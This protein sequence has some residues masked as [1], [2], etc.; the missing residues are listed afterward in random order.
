MYNNNFLLLLAFCLLHLGNGQVRGGKKK[1]DDLLIFVDSVKGDV[2]S[3]SVSDPNRKKPLM[4]D[5]VIT[6]KDFNFNAGFIVVAVNTTDDKFSPLIEV[7]YMSEFIES[8]IDAT[9]F[10]FDCTSTVSMM[11]QKIGPLAGD[12]NFVIV[13][14]SKPFEAKAWEKCTQKQKVTIMEY[15]WR[16]GSAEIGML[17]RDLRSNRIDEE[18][19]KS[20][21]ASKSLTL[22]G[23]FCN[24]VHQNS[25]YESYCSASAAFCPTLSIDRPFAPMSTTICNPDSLIVSWFLGVLITLALWGVSIFFIIYKQGGTIYAYPMDAARALMLESFRRLQQQGDVVLYNNELLADEAP[26]KA[27]FVHGYVDPL[28]KVLEEFRFKDVLAEDLCY[29]H[30]VDEALGKSDAGP[31]PSAEMRERVREGNYFQVTADTPI[32]EAWWPEGVYYPIHQVYP[33]GEDTFFNEP[34]T[35]PRAVL[36]SLKEGKKSKGKDKNKKHKKENG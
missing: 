31:V 20:V 2:T 29:W 12:E 11:D 22:V 13:V 15:L 28:R 35:L 10:P 5:F 1:D 21:T 33:N 26:K 14:V 32:R 36:D 23:R 27:N 25:I 18:M 8:S 24:T 16:F 9:K 19:F 6:G 17:I 30:Y 7:V 3:S 34:P 4:S